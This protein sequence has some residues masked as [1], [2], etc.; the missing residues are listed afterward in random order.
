MR[1]AIARRLRAVH[2]GIFYGGICSLPCKTCGRPTVGY[3][4]YCRRHTDLIMWTIQADYEARRAHRPPG[5]HV[6]V[7]RVNARPA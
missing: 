5:K 6:R 1:A 4:A 7:R 2:T 3:S